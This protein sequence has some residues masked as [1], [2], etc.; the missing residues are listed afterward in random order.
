MA[1]YAMMQRDVGLWQTLI[2]M[3]DKVAEYLTAIF[4][5]ARLTHKLGR[6]NVAIRRMLY[7]KEVPAVECA[8][9]EYQTFQLNAFGGLKRILASTSIASSVNLSEQPEVSIAS[10]FVI[11]G[12][13]IVLPGPDNNDIEDVPVKGI[14]GVVQSAG[15]SAGEFYSNWAGFFITSGDGGYTWL[16]L[17]T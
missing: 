11:D 3:T 16:E 5:A 1:I 2:L 10:P 15:Y 8:E 12:F 13:E 6:K 4:D 7:D 17:E 14:L 9:R